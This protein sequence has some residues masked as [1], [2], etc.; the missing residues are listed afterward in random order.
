MTLLK[1]LLGSALLGTVVTLT[2]GLFSFAKGGLQ[3]GPYRNK[4]MYLRVFFQGAAL[5]FF[6]LLLF[7]KGH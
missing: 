1:V 6:A 2:L 4:L 5:V 7:M 3:G